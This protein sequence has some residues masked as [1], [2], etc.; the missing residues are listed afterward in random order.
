VTLY[1]LH[2]QRILRLLAERRK[3]GD[4]TLKALPGDVRGEAADG[5][6]FLDVRS[7]RAGCEREND[8]CHRAEHHELIIRPAA[9]R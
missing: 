4:R 5:A 3:L 6:A 7:Q 9:V 8:R 1:A 2:H